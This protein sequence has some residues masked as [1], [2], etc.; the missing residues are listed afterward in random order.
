MIDAARVKMFGMPI[1]TLRL[2]NRYDVVSFQYDDLFA[3]Q[4]I[5]PAPLMMPVRKGVVYSFGNLERITYQGLP[6]MIADSLPDTY[7]RALFEKWL[8][9]NGRTSGNVIESLCYLG[10]RCMGALEC[11]PALLADSKPDMSFEIDSLVDVA[12]EA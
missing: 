2:D 6:G 4:G 10:N 8:S 9:L 5:E 12:S 3:N 7:G 1:G 11:E